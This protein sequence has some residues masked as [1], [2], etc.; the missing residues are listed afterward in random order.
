MHI[1]RDSVKSAMSSTQTTEASLHDGNLKSWLP[2][3]KPMLSNH[4]WPTTDGETSSSSSG[5]ESESYS[6][7]GNMDDPY[8]YP[9]P[10]VIRNTFID[11]EVAG[12]CQ[13]DEFYREREARSC[14]ASKICFVVDGAVDS[15]CD[16]HPNGESSESSGSLFSG[17]MPSKNT[18]VHFPVER[19]SL[20]FLE[21]R[22]TKSCPS[23]GV[24]MADG[25]WRVHEQNRTALQNVITSGSETE[26]GEINFA[27]V[28]ESVMD[29]GV[30]TDAQKDLYFPCAVMAMDEQFVPMMWLGLEAI[31][32]PPRAVLSLASALPE[33]DMGSPEMPTI[34]SVGHW[35]GTCRPCAFMARGCTS[36]VSCPFCHLCDPNE[37]KRR[38][39]DKISFM[40]EL[41]RWKKEQ[42][43]CASSDQHM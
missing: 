23:S 14:P 7:L 8:M 22:H 18:F 24:E 37:K 29:N 43:V 20:D 28:W 2:S 26:T 6:G 17:E 38:R 4:S 19:T 10:F 11:S 36:G 13:F 9:L 21:E 40:R 3:H 34:G 25:E 30:V 33:P 1:V 39:K 41:R 32:Q 5:D 31:Q 16:V 15:V 27:P 12:P 42:T 35:N